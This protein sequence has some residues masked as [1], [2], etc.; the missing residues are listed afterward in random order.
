MAQA[1]ERESQPLLGKRSS[2][3]RRRVEKVDSLFN[4]KTDGIGLINASGLHMGV[5][6]ERG[7]PDWHPAPTAVREAA[8][9]AAA[10]S[11]RHGQDISKVAIRFCLDHPTVATTLVGM[12]TQEEVQRNLRLLR[13][14]SDPQILKQIHDAVA[15][16][17]NYAW[18][19]GKLEN[20]G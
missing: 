14:Q 12:A 8:K 9:K 6:T 4:G 13:T 2:V 1:L 17:F 15:P 10:I 5:L 3:V 18:T 16:V 20:N 7:A 11:R 19:S